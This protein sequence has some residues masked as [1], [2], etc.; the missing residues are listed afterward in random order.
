MLSQTRALGQST[1]SI[2]IPQ[3]VQQRVI[4]E[5]LKQSRTSLL[6]LWVSRISEGGPLISSVQRD[7]LVQLIDKCQ[8]MLLRYI[9]SLPTITNNPSNLF[10]PEPTLQI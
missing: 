5:V 10:Y 8:S 3:K 4:Q 2:Q 9:G 1:L 7:F 6:F